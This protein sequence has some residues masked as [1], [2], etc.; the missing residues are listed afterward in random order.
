MLQDELI[1]PP[2]EALILGG[3]GFMVWGWWHSLIWMTSSCHHLS[4]KLFLQCS[5]AASAVTAVRIAV[6]PGVGGSVR[7]QDN[8]N[9]Y[10]RMFSILEGLLTFVHPKD[11]GALIVTQPRVL[12]ECFSH[13]K[14][15]RKIS[16]THCFHINCW[17][18]S[19]SIVPVNTISSCIKILL[20]LTKPAKSQGLPASPCST[21]TLILSFKTVF[22]VPRFSKEHR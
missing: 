6:T 15:Y 17:C 14:C 22:Y 2:F 20:R 5:W 1:A 8:P 19:G 21:L 12:S 3:K 10:E 16:L 9:I 11:Q 13:F 4:S 7:L 18:I